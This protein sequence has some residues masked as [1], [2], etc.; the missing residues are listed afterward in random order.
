MKH[1][2]NREILKDRGIKYTNQRNITLN[3][4]E[5]AELPLTAEQLFMKVKETD[6]TISLSTIYR[7]L[8]MFVHKELVLK[9][10]MADEN[11]AIYELNRMKHKHHLVCM[12]CKKMTVIEGCP[13]EKYEKTLEQTTSY[14]ITTHKL[15]LFGYCP[16]CQEKE[17]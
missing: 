13:L 4:L 1:V 11:R 2:N 15:E 12:G 16:L 10:N 17:K 5:Q 3:A 14:Q 6:S 9:S 8:D 7:I